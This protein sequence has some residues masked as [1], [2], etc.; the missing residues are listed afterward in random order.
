MTFLSKNKR[1]AFVHNGKIKIGRIVGTTQ[2]YS[3]YNSIN[4]YKIRRYFKTYDIDWWNVWS[5]EP[6]N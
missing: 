5:G 3:D 4:Q 1:V 2:R 6:L